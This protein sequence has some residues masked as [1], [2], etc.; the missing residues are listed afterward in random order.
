MGVASATHPD[1]Y[2]PDN[3]ARIRFEADGTYVVQIAAAEIGTGSWTALTQIAAEAL[4][5]PVQCV[6]ME[7]G[8]S[9]LPH[10]T[11]AG[12]SVGTRSWG[13]AIAAAAKAF[14]DQHGADPQ[15]GE[16]EA[17]APELNDDRCR[18]TPLAPS[19]PRCESTLTPGE[20]RVLADASVFSPSAAS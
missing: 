17:Q 6:R 10:A 8:D 9:S 7:I 20:I 14:R 4:G 18:G 12:G 3:A 16:T 1:W 11:N 19:S 15:P 13:A 2:E 5:C